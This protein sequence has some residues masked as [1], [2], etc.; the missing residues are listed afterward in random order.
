MAANAVNRMDDVFSIRVTGLICVSC[1]GVCA[2]GHVTVEF[3]GVCHYL[4]T[5]V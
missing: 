2:Y 4:N 5:S 1:A 3:G